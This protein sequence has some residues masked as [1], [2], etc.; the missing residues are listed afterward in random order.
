MRWTQEPASHAGHTFGGTSMQLCKDYHGCNGDGLDGMISD[1]GSKR[2]SSGGS[3]SNT[4][5]CN[6]AAME[7]SAVSYIV[8]LYSSSALWNQCGGS[9]IPSVPKLAYA[10]PLG[11]IRI[12][13]WFLL[14][15]P[16]SLVKGMVQNMS[17][18]LFSSSHLGNR[19]IV[20]R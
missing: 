17:L 2:V 1:Q 19:F 3:C 5:Q 14:D 10:F 20:R 16:G 9:T 13:M 4:Y 12:T 8:Q 15:V 6:D 18:R 11:S 7:R